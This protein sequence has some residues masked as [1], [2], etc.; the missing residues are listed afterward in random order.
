[1]IFL[2]I[3]SDWSEGQCS[4]SKTQ[5]EWWRKAGDVYRRVDALD[6][7]LTSRAAAGGEGQ[8]QRKETH[9]SWSS[10]VGAG[11]PF[12][13]NAGS[14]SRG[15]EKNVTRRTVVSRWVTRMTRTATRKQAQKTK[16]TD[17]VVGFKSTWWSS[18]G[19]S[20]GQGKEEHEQRASVVAR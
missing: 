1:M 8:A 13:L 3:T 14:A 11:G 16:E 10:S 4:L 2:D 19:Q 12:C 5:N 9:A 20:V 7:C 15:T 17:R 6:K 18:T